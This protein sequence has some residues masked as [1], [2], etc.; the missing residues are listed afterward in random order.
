MRVVVSKDDGLL[1]NHPGRVSFAYHGT[2][3]SLKI[4]GPCR[5]D[6]ASIVHSIAHS[7][8]PH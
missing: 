6:S 3:G 8:V 1:E 4:A 5:K 2:R 7:M